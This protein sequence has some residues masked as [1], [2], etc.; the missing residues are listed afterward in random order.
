MRPRTSLRGRMRDAGAPPAS[1]GRNAIQEDPLLHTQLGHDLIRFGAS[2]TII[3]I[4]YPRRSRAF[5]N[6]RPT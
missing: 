3:R 6:V 2:S 1:A 5:W 4:P